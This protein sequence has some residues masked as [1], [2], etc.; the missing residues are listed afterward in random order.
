MSFRRDREP[1]PEDTKDR[2]AVSGELCV[3]ICRK[4]HLDEFGLRCPAWFTN[5]MVRGKRRPRR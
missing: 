2:C 4:L 3:G 5:E 1:D